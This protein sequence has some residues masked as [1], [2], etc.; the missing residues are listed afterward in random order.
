MAVARP[1]GEWNVGAGASFRVSSAY[2]PFELGGE[3]ARY[4]PGNEYRLRLGGDSRL[5]GGRLAL[6]ATLAMFGDDA[7]GGST[8]ATGDRYVLQGAWSGAVRSLEV[9]VSGWNLTRGEGET[10]A[11]V[12][13]WE[14]ISNLAI[15]M[16]MDLGGAR[17]EPNVELRTWM[18]DAGDRASGLHRGD[19]VG[20][21]A[22]LGIR[23]QSRLGGL[24]LTPSAA[25]SLGGV[26]TAVGR[27]SLTGLRLALG[28]RLER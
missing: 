8:Y 24:L 26:Q 10:I 27:A 1:L 21:L 17:V 2:E 18:R 22:A 7:A 6:G 25:Y 15:S 28:A 9:M 19:N 12:A 20:R 23:A 3:R 13:P 11:G 16:A 14:N 5:L 4:E